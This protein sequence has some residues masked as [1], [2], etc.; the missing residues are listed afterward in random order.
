MGGW[1]DG[2]MGGW[3]NG[4]MDEWVD[5]WVNDWLDGWVD[6]WANECVKIYFCT[7]TTNTIFHPL[8][9]QPPI[10]GQD[11]IQVLNQGKYTL[12][13]LQLRL[14]PPAIRPQACVCCVARETQSWPG[15]VAWFLWRVFDGGSSCFWGFLWHFVVFSRCFIGGFW[16]CF[17][18]V[19]LVGFGGV[20]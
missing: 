14:V 9:Q 20:F 19:S 3:M 8:P 15:Q 7:S 13:P 5:G 12:Y 17:L 2:C 4:W 11:F 18:G 1:I 10:I 16:W 6:G